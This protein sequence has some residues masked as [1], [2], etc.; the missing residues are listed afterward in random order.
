MIYAIPL[1]LVP[2]S[3]LGADSVDTPHVGILVVMVVCVG[4]FNMCVQ[5]GPTI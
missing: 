2:G 4:Y 1:F 5:I 3:F